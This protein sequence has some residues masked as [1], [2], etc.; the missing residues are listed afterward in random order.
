MSGK[1]RTSRK[2]VTSN[3]KQLEAALDTYYPKGTFVID[4][5][6]CKTSDIVTL[7]EKEDTLNAAAVTAHAAWQ[8]AA[9][10]ARVQT[11]ANDQ[12]RI[13]LK[14]A[15][16]SLLGRTNASKLQE[17]GFPVRARTV[18]TAPT[19]AAAAQKAKAT[20]EARGTLGSKQRLANSSEVTPPVATPSSTPATAS[21]GAT[22][23]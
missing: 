10:A 20:R 19:K 9:G 8:I 3:N 4:G 6:T 21:N 5:Q 13:E 12:M 7:L 1:A 15:L 16:K 14:A 11:V 18:T 22:Q 2:I 23:K 17:F